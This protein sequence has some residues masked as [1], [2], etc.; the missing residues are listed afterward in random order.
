MLASQSS[1]ATMRKGQRT[2]STALFEAK[3]PSTTN[4]NAFITTPD[5]AGLIAE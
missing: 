2:L 1:A 3:T 4:Q 5:A